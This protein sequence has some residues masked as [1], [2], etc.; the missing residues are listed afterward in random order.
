MCHPAQEGPDG[1]HVE[2]N[3]S[4]SFNTL[5]GLTVDPITNPCLDPSAASWLEEDLHHSMHSQFE[6]SDYGI[7]LFREPVWILRSRG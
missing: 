5:Q 4:E 2:N 3:T 6:E 7:P 1:S